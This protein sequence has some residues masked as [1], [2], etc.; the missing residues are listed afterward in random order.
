MD[1]KFRIHVE[2][3]G[4]EYGLWIERSEE[5]MVRSAAKQLRRKLSQYRNTYTKHHSSERD[6]LAM[7]ALQLSIENLQWKEKN[8]TR[9]FT[10]TILRATHDL[11]EY[12]K[13]S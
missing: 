7:A 10:D 13:D 3:A 9:P 1:N 12:L 5:E 6:F 4:K 2:I 8:D 11:E